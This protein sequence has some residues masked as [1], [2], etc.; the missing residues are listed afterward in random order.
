MTAALG[1][2][3]LRVASLGMQAMAESSALRIVDCL[4][5]GTL[6]ALFGGVVSHFSRR[7]SSSLR[8]AVWFAA[9]IALA[10]SPFLSG[11]IWQARR[12]SASSGLAH[13]AIVVPGSWALYVFALWAAIAGLLMIRIGLGLWRL[14]ALRETFVPVD[15][16]G[17]EESVRETLNCG[18]GRAHVSLFTS[19]R[20]QVPAAI[21]LID[22]VVVVP[23]WALDEL[24]SSELSQVLLHEMAH[25]R[26]GDS[27]TNL[28]QQIIK[29]AFFFHPAVWWIE[30]KL[31]LEREM[32]CDDAVLAQ[33]ASPRAYAQCLKHIAEKS[34]L[35]RSLALAQAV[36]GRIR[37]TSMRVARILDASHS[38]GSKHGWRTAVSLATLLIVCGLIGANEPHLIAFQNAG[39]PL[40]NV[41]PPHVSAITPV[42]FKTAEAVVPGS[43]SRSNSV[44][45]L[46]ANHADRS[47]AHFA[48][49]KRSELL[50][51]AAK[52]HASLLHFAS[53]QVTGVHTAIP[54]HSQM[55]TSE[56]VFVVFENNGFGL[57]GQPIY[58][59]EVVHVT[60]IRTS[61]SFVSS[62]VLHKEI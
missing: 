20:V 45:A 61:T 58:E 5:A 50:V 26:R 15:L 1:V 40:Q 8:F 7:Q 32:A 30:R 12:G 34:L 9:L 25:L 22:P 6:I 48:A 62:E 44:R 33:I 36:L 38:R 46:A 2:A 17:L 11:V 4:F 28:A 19:D 23:Q 21:G 53:A 18:R 16:G 59:I 24:S 3:S 49:A 54:R 39:A 56:A 60:V 10:V 13:A 31:S 37:Q 41:I 14:R 51:A 52:N 35:R 55:V 42:S 27:W 29:A 57:S 43:V 47:A